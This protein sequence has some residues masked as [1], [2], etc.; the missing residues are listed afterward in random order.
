MDLQDTTPTWAG[1]RDPEFTRDQAY[2]RIRDGGVGLR[3]T[4][5]RQPFLSTMCNIAPAIAGD[6]DQPSM[7]PSLCDKAFGPNLLQLDTAEGGWTFF[8]GTGCPMAMALASCIGQV[9]GLFNQASQDAGDE[10]V[11]ENAVLGAP[12]NI[13][14]IGVKKPHKQCFDAIQ[15]KRAEAQMRRAK[16]IPRDDQRGIAFIQSSGDPFSSALSPPRPTRGHPSPPRSSG[17]RH[18]PSWAPHNQPAHP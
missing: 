13:F 17:P 7:W 18:R 16:A 5:E 1:Q 2:L 11:P 9:K 6:A 15:A 8:F 10:Q 4:L 14:G 12:D 3:D